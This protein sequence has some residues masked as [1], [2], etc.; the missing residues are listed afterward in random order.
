MTRDEPEYAVTAA[1][2]ALI[3]GGLAALAALRWLL[4]SGA[5]ERRRGRGPRPPRTPIPRRR[6]P[7]GRLEPPAGCREPSGG[8]DSGPPLRPGFAPP[9]DMGPGR[10][11]GGYAE[12]SGHLAVAEQVSATPFW[13]GGDDDAY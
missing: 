4:V 10:R 7:L 5:G 2:I 8:H 12:D 13:A 9:P 11:V 3:A 6:E 1:G